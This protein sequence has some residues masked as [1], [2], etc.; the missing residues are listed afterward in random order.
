MLFRAT[1]EEEARRLT[2]VG[3]ALL[4]CVATAITLLVVNPFRSRPP[5]RIALTIDTPYAGQGVAAGTAIIMHG[6]RVGEVTNI[7]SVADGGVRLN[8][9]LQSSSTAGLTD[10]LGIDFR[11]ANYFGVT[12]IN[13]VKGDGGQPLRDGVQIDT[14][15]RGNFTLQTLL[16]RLGQI[17][18]GVVTPQL[19]G[20]IDRST[21]YIDGLDPLLETM[22]TVI[23]AVDKV[24]TVS[25][26]QLLTNA[27]GLSAAFPAFV[28]ALTKTGHE[29]TNSGLVVFDH[30]GGE[31]SEEFWQNTY[32]PSV[33]LTAKGLFSAIGKLEASHV[34]NLIPAVGIIKILSDT[35]PGLVRPDD[36][37]ATLVE[38][39]T[40]FEKLYGGTPE[41]RAL[42]VHIVLDA[43]PGMAAPL[44]AMGV[45]P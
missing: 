38:L 30:T 43:L 21:R 16:S 12:G 4:L 33:E 3:S 45:T 17:T 39:R 11:P 26:A 25:T 22:L 36:I 31:V 42:Q 37:G 1:A 13:L 8:V 35:V 15:P 34:D 18:Q 23:E 40:R 44:G 28:D 19:V 27:T 41:Q 9:D 20:V 6:V 32:L 10:S 5:D 29:F 24:Q 14:T 2:Y 7:S